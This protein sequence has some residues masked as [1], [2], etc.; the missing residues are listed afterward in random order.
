[1]TEIKSAPCKLLTEFS[2]AD[3]GLWVSLREDSKLGTEGDGVKELDSEGPVWSGDHS[4]DQC[5]GDG[6]HVSGSVLRICDFFPLRGSL[7]VVLN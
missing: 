2:G 6:S 3:D 5:R 7:R 4:L 1:M